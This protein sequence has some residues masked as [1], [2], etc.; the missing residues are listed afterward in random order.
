MNS[1]DIPEKDLTVQGRAFSA[2]QTLLKL[3]IGIG[4]FKERTLFTV[5]SAFALARYTEEQI[6]T[7]HP[8]GQ[9]AKRENVPP[10]IQ[11]LE[12]NT[13]LLRSSALD[14]QN[15]LR[16]LVKLPFVRSVTGH[17]SA[18][19]LGVAQAL[20]SASEYRWSLSGL[21]TFLKGFQADSPLSL[22][23]LWTFPIALK[24]ALLE[25]I[26][27]QAAGAF[28]NLPASDAALNASLL[29]TQEISLTDWPKQLEPL[30]P[31]EDIL[32]QDP[33][34]T[35]AGMDFESRDLYR[36]SISKIAARSPMNEV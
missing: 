33:S 35:Y 12:E 10:G 22:E 36:I 23:E 15:A 16:T 14:V 25:E 2:R 13:R 34:N 1:T 29:C 27:A 30:V 4:K 20:L 26:L 8:Q 31:F 28:S 5:A 19:I 24:L 32:R 9:G 11:R 3:P 18:R 17:E 7:Q 21:S 6:R